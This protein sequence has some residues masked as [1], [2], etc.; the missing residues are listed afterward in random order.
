MALTRSSYLAL[1]LSTVLAGNW[2][3]ADPFIPKVSG[4]PQILGN[5]TDPTI[6]RDSCGSTR[7]G[8]RVLWT[9]R[10]S[11]PYDS[12]GVPTLP[13]YSSSASWTDFNSDGTPLIQSG[14]QSSHGDETGLLCYGDNNETP[15]FPI[16]QDECSDNSAGGC[17]DGT[18]WALWPNVPPL[19]TFGDPTSGSV[20][21]WTW[22]TQA[23][24]TSGLVLLNPDPPT[25]LYQINYD[26]ST[27]SSNPNQLPSVVLV[28]ETFWTSDQIP[29]G[30]YGN[31]VVNGTAYLYGQNA[32][33]TVGLAQVPS[34][35]VSNLT[36]YQYYVNDAWTTTIP[37]V[38]DTGVN[39]PNASAGGQGTYYYSTIWDLYV[40]IGQQSNTIGGYFY[41]TT[42]PAP[43]GPWAEPVN[44]LTVETN[45]L[46]YT[47]QAHPG[48]ISDANEN[49]IYLSW[50]VSTSAGYYTPLA[51]VEWE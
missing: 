33:G 30:T 10:D 21:A 12:N 36:A 3:K 40:W 35:Q 7:F 41:V 18:R 45:G 2:A 46:P 6:C 37:G 44:F 24:I 50:T 8:S 14:I 29:Y 49:A 19:F 15:F 31:L 11:E 23:H 9:C 25:A 34:D 39:I 17:S 38:N 26:G 47:F 16:P 28:E 43:E 5:V 22:I 4:T 32:N 20:T 27:G 51:Y 48:L 42:A 13:V 1:S